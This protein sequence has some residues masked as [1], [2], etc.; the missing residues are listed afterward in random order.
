MG[1][2]SHVI[3]IARDRSTPE[4]SATIAPQMH[5]VVVQYDAWRAEVIM[6]NSGNAQIGCRSITTVLLSGGIDSAALM[7]FL[8]ANGHDPIR[9]LHI[10]Y[11]QA[12][13]EHERPAAMS[14]AKHFEVPLQVVK[15]V[16]LPPAGPGVVYARN[17]LLVTIAAAHMC[18]TDG[19]IALGI[20]GGTAYDDCQPAFVEAMQ[21]VLDIYASGSLRVLA[22]FISW[23]KHQ[24]LDYAALH[25]LPVH[26]TRSCEA[27]TLAP[28]GECLS[29]KD[30]EA[31]NAGAGTT[32]QLSR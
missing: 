7:H 17:A 22:P 2:Y 10:D 26:L 30:L 12:A 1:G 3:G 8:L 19:F 24:V 29:C 5:R 20:H 11:G 9:A 16:G 23:S 27:D 13:R 32:T 25:K 14:I 31:I 18:S 4:T 6:A 28:C 21:N 15:T